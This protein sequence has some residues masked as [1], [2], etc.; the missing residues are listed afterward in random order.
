M[1][2]FSMIALL[3]FIKSKSINREE[4]RGRAGKE[5]R[6]SIPVPAVP[7]SELLA[8]KKPDN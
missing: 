5:S 6:I 8:G 4:T 7:V 3:C 1:V 2:L